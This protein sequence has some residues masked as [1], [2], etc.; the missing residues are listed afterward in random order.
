MNGDRQPKSA[1]TWDFDGFTLDAIKSD[2]SC[3]TF[4]LGIFQWLPRKRGNGVKRGRVVRRVRGYTSHAEKVF[5]TAN[6]Y[7]DKM[8]EKAD[9]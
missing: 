4:S 1:G 3:V 2:V 7:V 6:A 5:D 8:N 9:A